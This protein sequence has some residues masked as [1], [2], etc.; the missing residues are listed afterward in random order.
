MAAGSVTTYDGIGQGYARRRVPDSRLAEQIDAAL[1]D[2]TVVANVG[3]GTGA[4]EPGGR[5]IIP[6]EPSTTMIAQRDPESAL[7]VRAVAESL[8]LP[9]GSVDAALALLTVHHWSDQ[10]AGLRELRRVAVDRVV[11]LTWDEAVSE[12]RFW[13]LRDYLPEV[14]ASERA[15]CPSPAMVESVL[16]PCRTEAVLIPV[17]CTD[18]FFAAY[19]GRPEAYLDAEVRASISTLAQADP[20]A[21]DDAVGHLGRDIASGAWAMRY[22]DLADHDALDLGYRLVV[23]SA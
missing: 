10:A 8:P 12:A 17:D 1:G 15:R 23:A 11:V 2:A 6:V 9:D 7:A 13:M 14:M 3:A 18:G 16:G 20:Q 4:Y 5:R 22:A 21:V 19:W